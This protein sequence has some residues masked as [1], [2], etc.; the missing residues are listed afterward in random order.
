MADNTIEVEGIA[1]QI[2]QLEKM[3]TTNPRLREGIQSC[4]RKVL[5]EVQ[6][7]L[8]ADADSGLQMKS[9]PRRAYK[10]VR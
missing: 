10:A 3:M 9:D 4:V 1:E 2:K 8:S 6:K 7:Q 5:K